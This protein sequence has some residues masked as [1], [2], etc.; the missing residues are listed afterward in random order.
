[1]NGWTRT[2]L[3]ST[4]PVSPAHLLAPEEGNAGE[5]ATP[6]PT[7]AENGGAAVAVGRARARRRGAVGRG[8]VGRPGPDAHAAGPRR[9]RPPRAG[10]LT[11]PPL[12]HHFSRLP[13]A[14]RPQAR[15]RTR[16][17]LVL[18]FQ[19]LARSEFRWVPW[20]ALSFFS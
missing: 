14:C 2:R 10:A 1:M 7:S 11:S 13:R 18:L 20:V 9:R 4:P 3:A 17:R 6:T 16:P 19:P 12:R 5:A 8:E 15:K